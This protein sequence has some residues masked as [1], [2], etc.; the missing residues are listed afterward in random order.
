MRY[1]VLA[2]AALGLSVLLNGCTCDDEGEAKGEGI[3]GGGRKVKE[4]GK[5]KGEAERKVKDEAKSKG[6]AERKVKDE[7]KGSSGFVLRVNAGADKEYVDQSGTKWLPDQEFSEGKQYGAVG[8]RT[9]LRTGIKTVEGTKAPQVYLTERYEMSAYK[10]VLPKGDYKVRLHF[11]ETYEGIT[12]A[13]ERVFGVRINGQTVLKELDV[14]KETKG[15]AKPLVK[16][17]NKVQ[18]AD[19]KLLI[20]FVPQVQNAEINGIEILGD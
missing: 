12:S 9:V 17:F 6:E 14:F 13:G 5:G 3:S 1:L 8:G 15:L 16:E 18:V 11:A 4:E 19:G 7:G 10:F 2:L 20:E